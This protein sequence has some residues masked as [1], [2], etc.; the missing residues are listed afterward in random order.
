MIC[1]YRRCFSTCMLSVM[2]SCL[3]FNFIGLIPLTFSVFFSIAIFCSFLIFSSVKS[4]RFLLVSLLLSC[5][6]IAHLIFFPILCV[7][8]IRL[9]KYTFL[10][11]ALFSSSFPHFLYSF[12]VGFRLLFVAITLYTI[13]F[14]FL[15]SSYIVFLPSCESSLGQTWTCLRTAEET[16]GK[17]KLSQ[18]VTLYLG[19]I[20]ICFG[21]T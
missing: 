19:D 2:C 15:V 14:I 11:I 7:I 8:L 16:R 18:F 17:V 13:F 12:T 1:V 3:C 10:L 21:I 4:F 5:V 9:E 6:A 20:D